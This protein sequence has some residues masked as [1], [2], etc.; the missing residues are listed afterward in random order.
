MAEPYVT[1]REAAL[2]LGIGLSTL[3]GWAARGIVRPAWRTPGG[4]A[5]WDVADLRRQLGMPPDTGDELMA[6]PTTPVRQPIAAAIVTSK[7]GVLIERRLDGRPLW[8]FPSGE[9]EPG[10]SPADAAVREVKEECGLAVKVSHM[11]GERN[12]P[13]T[14]RHMIY[15]AARS[16]Q[17]TDV[18]NGDEAELAEVRWATFAEAERLMPDMFAPAHDHLA[19]TLRRSA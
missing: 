6:E 18:H 16:Y 11:I 1:S 15:L 5:R 19:R 12:H 3:Q 2:R 17:G 9:V 13:R 7:L 8:T 14:G 4:Q 10:E